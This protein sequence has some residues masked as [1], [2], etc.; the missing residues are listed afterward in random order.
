MC[1]EQAFS[2]N[3]EHWSE[4]VFTQQTGDKMDSDTRFDIEEC[5][6]LTLGDFQVVV[7]PKQAEWRLVNN[8]GREILELL[9]NKTLG[10][11]TDTLLHRSGIRSEAGCAASVRAFL[12]PLLDDGLIAPGGETKAKEPEIPK[13]FALRHVGFNLTE[14]C[15]LRCLHCFVNSSPEVD[16][17]KELSDEEALEVIASLVVLGKPDFTFSG[18]EPLLRQDLLITIL[19]KLRR[20]DAAENIKV[21]TNGLLMT[22]KLAERLA[23]FNLEVQISLDGS[24]A[25][26]HDFIRGH[27]SF[28]RAVAALKMLISRGI[29]TSTCTT[30][31]KPNLANLSEIVRFAISLG[32]NKVQTQLM[33]PVG[34]SRENINKIAIDSNT[35]L[36]AMWEAK[37]IADEYD[38]W[39]HEGCSHYSM[40][41]GKRVRPCDFGAY[42]YITSTGDLYPCAG[43]YHPTMRLGNVLTDDLPNIWHHSPI[44]NSLRSTTVHDFEE[45]RGCAYRYFCGGGCRGDV[46]LITNDFHGPN[47]FCESEKRIIKAKIVQDAAEALRF[48]FAGQTQNDWSGAQV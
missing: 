48:H 17:I 29:K 38:V 34:R 8:P 27:G 14:A 23:G 5:Q 42:L 10:E 7:F 21:I 45:C 33:I 11:A 16:R 28:D 18:G 15:N 12:A 41:N 47:P 19:E 32:V 22:E 37:Q 20:T 25:E 6:F 35:G 26:V 36:A 30:V 44:L 1:V 24:N 9:R 4:S 31:M 43:L 39:G 46:F 40:C 13:H 2:S 3:Q